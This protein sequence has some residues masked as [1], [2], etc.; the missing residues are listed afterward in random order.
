MSAI[1][2]H[3]PLLGER[4]LGVESLFGVLDVGEHVSE[5]RYLLTSDQRLDHGVLTALVEMRFV[6]KRPNSR[7]QSH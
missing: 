7:V 3:L 1:L 4:H 5:L 2:A 6:Q